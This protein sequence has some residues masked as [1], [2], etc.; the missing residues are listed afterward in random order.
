MKRAC[1]V[2]GMLGALA[3]FAQEPSGPAVITADRLVVNDRAQRAHFSGHVVLVRGTFR[4]Q[5]PSLVAHYAERKGKYVLVRAEAEGGVSF[6]DARAHGR[7]D[8]AVYEADAQR[9]VLL[10]HA[11]VERADG[12]LEGARIV[13]SLGTGETRAEPE[14]GGRVKLRIETDAD[15]AP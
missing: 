10:G 11:V 14:A 9:I 3:A 7:A 6:V 2:L 15:Q 13:H 8:R 1:L 5:C 12:R 4:L